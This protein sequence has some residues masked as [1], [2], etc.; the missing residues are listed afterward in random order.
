MLRVFVFKGRSLEKIFVLARKLYN[1]RAPK[2]LLERPKSCSNAHKSTYVVFWALAC[3]NDLLF[4][5]MESSSLLYWLTRL[6][7]GW[8]SERYMPL[9]YTVSLFLCV[10]LSLSLSFSIPLP[11]S[12]SLSMSFIYR[13]LSVSVLSLCM[14]IPLSLHL[15]LSLSSLVSLCLSVSLRPSLSLSVCM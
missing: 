11:L 7:F 15:S 5:Q 2:V 4:A 12:I 6:T 1:N 10:S 14:R 3:K 9:T 13:S 8:S